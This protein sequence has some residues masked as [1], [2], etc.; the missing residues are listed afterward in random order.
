MSH[1]HKVTRIAITNYRGVRALDAK[2]GPGGAVIKGR[3]GGGKTSV[4]R[5]IRA[6]LAAQDISPDA[7]TIGEERAEILIDVDDVSVQRVI[8]PKTTTVKAS[9]GGMFAAKPQTFLN[10]LLGNAAIDPLDLFL[11]KDKERRAVILEAL[12][13]SVSAAQLQKWAPV[14]DDVDTSGHGL[15]VLSR[16]RKVFYDQRTDANRVKDEAEREVARIS[17]ILAKMPATTG[18]DLPD[19]E[20][21][22]DAARAAAAGLHQQEVDAEATEK[23]QAS[24]RASLEGLKAEAAKARADAVAIAKIA[25]E[26]A[27]REAFDAKRAEAEQLA[28]KLAEVRREMQAL[29]SELDALV[30][31]NDTAARLVADA[32]TKE[33]SA[34]SIEQ[35]LNATVARVTP[36]QV[37]QI[38]ARVGAAKA[39][40][41]EAKARAQRAEV[42]RQLDE[43]KAKAAR[44]TDAALNLDQIVKRLTDDAPVAL[45]AAA[46]G[47]PG[48]V[49]DDDKILLDGVDI[50]KLSG[51]GQMQFAVTVA[52]RLNA[53]S[54]MLVVDGM[55][56]LD[57]DNIQSFIKLATADGWQLLATRVASGEVVI[58]A[59]EA[60]P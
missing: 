47:I 43:A 48:L 25:E 28:K 55:E 35:T 53:K 50:D 32:E 40:V 12:P 49:L 27:K 22:L 3:N 21:E 45:V 2:I 52:K 37:A 24:A 31:V 30:D 26:Q 38:G 11:K 58:E 8:T 41:D 59:I 51:A 29:G 57:E 42:A 16:V 46:N 9:R 15:V 4:L 17:A 7:I 33:R 5:A 20:A 60:S 10:E 19:A 34:A 14:P 36:E 6:A 13:V 18:P 39:A 56:R 1:G 54:K 44:A 23:R